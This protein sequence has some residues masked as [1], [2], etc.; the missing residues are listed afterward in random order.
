MN[1]NKKFCE[2]FTKK[3]GTENVYLK[4]IYISTIIII[5][6]ILL[7]KNYL[8]QSVVDKGIFKKNIVA[9][10]RIEVIDTEKTE[11]RKKEIANRVD[12]IL[13]P[14]HDEHIINNYANLIA[15]IDMVRK[16]SYPIETKRKELLK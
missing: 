2:D 11:Q 12:P 15:S 4:I 5:A 14:F 7:S 10:Q 16:S 3:F 1:I 8:F 13:T 9:N 6:A